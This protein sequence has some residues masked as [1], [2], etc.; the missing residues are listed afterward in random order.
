ME[1]QQTSQQHAGT[2]PKRKIE[3][4]KV[5][6]LGATNVGKT[7][8]FDRVTKNYFNEAVISSLS[9]SFA[10]KTM[11]VT[12]LL[13]ER[14]QSIPNIEE[15]KKCEKEKKS[16]NERP[17]E[18][19]GECKLT[20]T[21]SQA[22]DITSEQGQFEDVLSKS[23]DHGLAD[24][25]ENHYKRASIGRK[26]TE[27]EITIRLNLWDTVGSE[28]YASLNRQYFTDAVCAIIVY[29]VTDAESLANVTNWLNL[30]EQNCQGPILKVLA[31]NKTDLVEEIVVSEEEGRQ[32]AQEHDFDKVYQVS[33]RSGDGL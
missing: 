4:F 8:I 20:L 10:A 26:F 15:M 29:D 32:F 7:C 28:R 14:G 22:D 27:Q 19:K 2:V 24:S 25:V 3:N 21:V 5:I 31:G 16:A 33:A 18:P 12:K 23:K 6:L 30:L 13:D 17:Q 1:D 11:R 9:H